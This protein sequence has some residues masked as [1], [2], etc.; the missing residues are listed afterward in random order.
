MPTIGATDVLVRTST[1]GICRTDLHIQDGLAYVPALPHIPG[2]EPAGVVA[3]V[4]RDVKALAVGQRVA[5][6]LFFTCGTCWHCQTGADAQCSRVRGILGVTKAGAFAEYFAAPA[7]NLIALPD[8][9]DFAAGGLTSCAAVTALHAVERSRV[10]PG[11][12]AAVIGVG[13]VGQLIVQILKSVGIRVVAIDRSETSLQSALQSG[14]AALVVLVDDANAAAQTAEFSG[15]PGVACVLDCVGTSATLRT[16]TELVRNGGRIVVIGEEAD[17][18]PITSTNIAQREIEIIGSR[19]GS[20]RNAADAV[21]MLADGRM[22]P[23]IDRRFP[24]EQINEAFNYVR[25]G[26]AHGRVVIA[27]QE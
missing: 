13:G 9:V 3:A 20:R 11:D 22:K 4:G 26:A 15:A 19:N 24:L 5:P 18:L 17:A 25:S 27:I 7:M 1:C 8:S 10:T 6:H 23:T 14:G 2:H 12:V 21:A 16:A